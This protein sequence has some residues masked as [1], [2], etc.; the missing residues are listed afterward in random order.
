[1]GLISEDI[2]AEIQDHLG[3]EI[4]FTYNIMEFARQFDAHVHKSFYDRNSGQWEMVLNKDEPPQRGQP[5]YPMSFKSRDAALNWALATVEGLIVLAAQEDGARPL[6]AKKEKPT[7]V[8]KAL[9]AGTLSNVS[10]VSGVSMGTLINWHANKRKLFR[11]VCLGVAAD[12][13]ECN[14]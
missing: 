5:G 2:S 10:E 11:L 7:E 8:A 9:G 6:G 3:R 13:K 4:G 12:S 14:K 1:M